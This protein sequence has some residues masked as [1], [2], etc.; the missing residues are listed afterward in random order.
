MKKDQ[1]FS[2][3]LPKSKPFIFDNKVAEVFEDMLLRSV[4]GYADNLK[5]IEMFAGYFAR[6]QADYY[7][8]GSSLCAASIALQKGVK[9]KGR[10]IYAIDNSPAMIRRSRHIISGINAAT[11]I[12]LI[13]ADIQDVKIKNAAIVLMNYTLQF[14]H[15]DL[16]D[17]L[18]R[19][20]YEG[21][22]PGG[23]LLLSEK[24][25]FEQPAES[26]FQNN[27]YWTFK[28]FNGYS[29]MEISQKRN[30]L[31]NVLIPETWQTH[32]QRLTETGFKEVYIWQ[33]FFNFTSVFAKK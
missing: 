16:R 1:I 32:K 15:P 26:E 14:I 5:M 6:E 28:K 7:D 11:P 4:P 3:P 13:C 17:A 25:V 30:A 27:W 29:R 33:R 10:C 24:M 21:L 2:R 22:L 20:V 12:R 8:L 23:L 18:L 9:N 31:E 19:R